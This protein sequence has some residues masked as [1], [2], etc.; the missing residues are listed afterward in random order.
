MQPDKSLAMAE[1]ETALAALVRTAPTDQQ[2]ELRKN[3]DLLHRLMAP[4]ATFSAQEFVAS[5]VANA[6]RD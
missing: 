3:A 4:D 1:V 2:A 6:F 5:E